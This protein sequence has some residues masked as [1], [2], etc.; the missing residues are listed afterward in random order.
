MMRTPVKSQQPQ[1]GS[2]PDLQQNTDSTSPNEYNNILRSNK[3]RRCDCEAECESK[4]DSFINTLTAWRQDTDEKLSN[5]Q[6]CMYE[7]KKQNGE[8]LAS[9]AEIERSIDFLSQKYDDLNIKLN[10]Y[11]TKS[12]EFDERL[13]KI[14]YNL[15]DI[16]RTTRL[17]TLEIR[18]LSLKQRMTQEEL[19]DITSRVF[20]EL[21]VEIVHSD[22]YDIRVLPSKSENKT[23]LVTLNSIITKNYILKA[24]KEYNRQSNSKLNTTILME[25]PPRKI[26]I[27]EHL[28]SR[29]RKL[30]HAAREFAKAESFKHCWTAYGRVLWRKEDNAKLIVVSSELQLLEIKSKN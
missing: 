16:D 28:T 1:Y 17:S 18:N 9:N 13:S 23:I 19:I 14:E 26:Y 22:L 3:R 30:F 27:A 5:I 8:L 6:S 12:K 15:D 7:I 2:A 25:D 4:L 10:D 21:S 11:Q 24:Y 20:K 29:T